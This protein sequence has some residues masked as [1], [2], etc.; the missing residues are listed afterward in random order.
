MSQQALAN[1]EK[2][3]MCRLNDGPEARQSGHV[4]DL[5]PEDT[6]TSWSLDDFLDIVP[7][8]SPWENPGLIEVLDDF[9]H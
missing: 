3:A 5:S 9:V 2:R 4:Q 8:S 6:V 1:P 7:R